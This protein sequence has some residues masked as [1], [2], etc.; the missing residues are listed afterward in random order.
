MQQINP[1]KRRM[2]RRFAMQAIYQW[3]LTQNELDYISRQFTVDEYARQ[4]DVEFFDKILKGVLEQHQKLCE[5]L[6]SVLDRPL[7]KIDPIERSILLLATFE[8][9]HCYESPHRVVINEAIELAKIYGGE[10]SF[11][12][13]N[14]LLD[15]LMPTLRPIEWR[16]SRS[17]TDK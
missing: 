6:A 13:V 15:K 8:F 4:M 1:R 12:Y 3:L 11:K 9:A 5:T 17:K 14:A 10:D 2:S 16:A 7:D